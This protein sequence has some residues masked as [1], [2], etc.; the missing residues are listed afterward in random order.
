M[1]YDI[2]GN[3]AVVDDAISRVVNEMEPP[4]VW[5]G[6]PLS[7]RAPS[8]AKPI[9]IGCVCN[10]DCEY[11]LYGVRYD[12]SWVLVDDLDMSPGF[13]IEYRLVEVE[14]EKIHGF[15]LIQRESIFYS[16]KD[17]RF[18]SLE[19]NVGVAHSIFLPVISDSKMQLLSIFSLPENKVTQQWLAWDKE[20]YLFFCDLNKSKIFCIFA[21]DGSL[22][23][24]EDH[25]ILEEIVEKIKR[26]I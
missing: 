4:K 18:D 15:S 25:Y 16:N 17:Y 8:K 26:K 6:F 1:H 20:I 19:V 3:I 7:W 2:F 13:F 22:Q 10:S 5:N 21:H 24:S 12:M 9:Y 23:S 14:N 11:H